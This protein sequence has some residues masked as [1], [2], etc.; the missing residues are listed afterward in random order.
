LF[1]DGFWIFD[2]YQQDKKVDFVRD[3]LSSWY[4]DP[5][6]QQSKLDFRVTVGAI[7]VVIVW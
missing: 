6:Y 1:C 3:S 5:F 2:P 4:L 7:V